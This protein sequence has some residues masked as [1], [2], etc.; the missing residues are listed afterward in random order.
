[1]GVVWRLV[2]VIRLVF[3]SL[4]LRNA[5][6]LEGVAHVAICDAVERTSVVLR[7]DEVIKNAA[8]RSVQVQLLLIVTSLEI[9]CPSRPRVKHIR[10]VHFL[11]NREVVLFHVLALKSCFVIHCDDDVAVA[12][13][14]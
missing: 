3:T 11:A 12:V 8:P 1:M 9:Y 4:H 2:V 14:V 6:H 7:A 13:H 10:K 5:L